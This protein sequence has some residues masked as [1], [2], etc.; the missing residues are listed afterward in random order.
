MIF[1]AEQPNGGYCLYFLLYSVKQME[2]L[3]EFYMKGN[4]LNKDL[5]LDEKLSTLKS[6]VKL[7]LSCCKLDEIPHR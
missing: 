5:T 4:K 7:N 2:F 3:S 1:D 6:L